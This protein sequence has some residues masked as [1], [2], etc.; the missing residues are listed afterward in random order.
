MGEGGSGGRDRSRGRRGGG[1]EY[2]S[3]LTARVKRRT[4]RP[5]FGWIDNIFD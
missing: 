4:R 2:L 3:T 1:G 5:N